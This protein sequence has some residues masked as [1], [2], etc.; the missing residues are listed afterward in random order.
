MAKVFDQVFAP[1]GTDETAS[2]FV[3]VKK[4]ETY[5]WIEERHLDLAINFSLGLEVAQAELLRINGFRSPRDKLAVLQ[6][7]LQLLVDLIKKKT[8]GTASATDSLLPSLI[9]VI[10]RAN[11]SKLISNLKY[12]MRYRNSHEMEKGENQFCMTNFVLYG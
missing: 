11:P 8:D 2:N 1:P 6:N 3:L 9:L 4:I 12:V 10:I 5:G 7:V